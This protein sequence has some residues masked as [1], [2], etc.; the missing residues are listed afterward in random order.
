MKHEKQRTIRRFLTTAHRSTPQPQLSARWRA[1]VMDAVSHE[2]I[3][4]P[5]DFERLAPK[6]TLAATAA[7]LIL[8]VVAAWSLNGLSDTLYT[9]Y[10]SQTLDIP[11]NLWTSM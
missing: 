8:I 6:F 3:G 1:S 7:S 10:A 4:R 2:P 9:L 5:T 11:S